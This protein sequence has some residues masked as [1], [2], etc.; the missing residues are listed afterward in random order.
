MN[1]QLEMRWLIMDGERVLQ[2]RFLVSTVG[3]QWTYTNWVT[4]PEVFK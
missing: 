4:V 1:N 2:Y 3:E